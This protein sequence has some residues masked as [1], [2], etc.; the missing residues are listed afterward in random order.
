MTKILIPGGSTPR[1]TLRGRLRRH[2]VQLDS[3]A[4]ARRGAAN[5]LMPTAVL[6]LAPTASGDQPGGCRRPQLPFSIVTEPNEPAAPDEPSSPQTLRQRVLDAKEAEAHPV[7]DPV[8]MSSLRAALVGHPARVRG[9]VGQNVTQSI[10]GRNLGIASI[11]KPWWQ[12]YAKGIGITAN[13]P[14]QR[15]LDDVAK[16][17]APAIRL[18]DDVSRKAMPAQSQ[19]DGIAKMISPT[20]SVIDSLPKFSTGFMADSLI[21]KKTLSL[22][23]GSQAR[24]FKFDLPKFDFHLPA[25]RFESE[26]FKALYE[27]FKPRNLRSGVHDIDEIEAIMKAEGIPFCMVPDAETITALLNADDAGGRRAVLRDRADWIFASCDDVISMCVDGLLPERGRLIRASISAYQNGHPEAAQAL[28]TVVLDQLLADHR[29]ANNVKGATTGVAFIETKM[30]IREAF[31]F[32]PLP[33]VHIK[34]DAITDHDAFN[35]HATVHKNTDGQ[36][37]PSNAVQSV[38]LATSLLGYYQ[39]LW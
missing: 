11:P 9:L 37:T 29:W 38:M 22:I 1:G 18:I 15:L 2:Q 17:I 35:R 28:A 3:I 8:Q 6:V 5:F 4:E 30:D 10:V 24:A 19:L 20:Q 7:D 16:S 12:D 36:L 39:D 21:D 23:T 26:T 25:F 33:V 14:S 34:T 32:L 31:Y 27:R 13:V